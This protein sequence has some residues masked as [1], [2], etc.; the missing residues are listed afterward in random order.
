[1]SLVSFK[2]NFKNIIK[3]DTFKGS[4]FT[5]TNNTL[6]VPVNLT[7]ASIKMQLKKQGSTTSTAL[8]ELSTANGLINITDAVNGVFEINPFIMNI[9]AGSYN[10][11]MQFIFSG[12]VIQTYIYGTWTVTEDVTS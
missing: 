2:Y 8:L 3:G 11:D 12:N 5:V 6:A 9:P 10:Y 1:M 4:Q 7:G